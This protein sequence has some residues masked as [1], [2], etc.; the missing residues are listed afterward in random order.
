MDVSRGGDHGA[1]RVAV[2]LGCGAL[3]VAEWRW[4]VHFGVWGYGLVR[5]GLVE[6]LGDLLGVAWRLV[7][8]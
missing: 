4:G 5:L 8:W 3:G 2:A 1:V 7:L 6:G